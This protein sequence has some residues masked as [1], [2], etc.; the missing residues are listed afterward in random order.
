MPVSSTSVQSEI[1]AKG[2][3]HVS[4]RQRLGAHLRIARLDHS[5]KQLFIL[6]GI[7]LAMALTG[8]RMD[9]ALAINLCIGMISATLIASSNYVLN[10][11]LD[12]P[13]DRQHPTKKNRPAAC[14]LV[15]FGWGYAQ[16]ILMMIAG[17]TL[18]NMLFRGFLFSAIALWVMGCIYN[19]P[20][21][22]SK[23]LPYVDVL[24]ESI[25]NPIRFCL[26]WYMVTATLLPPASVLVSYW[27]LGAYFMALKRFSEYRQIGDASVAGSYRK[28]F[29]Y[30]NQESLLNSVVFYAAASMLFFGA[31]IMR[32]RIELILLFPLVAWLMAIYFGLSFRRESAVQNPEKLYREPRLMLVLALCTAVSVVLLFVNIPWLTL[33]FPRSL[34]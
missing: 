2:L 6:P 26:G 15:S 32:Y 12:A 19:I 20:P 10:E 14:R 13:F 34:P 8:R 33:F 27:M 18:A 1:L 17:L 21:I 25:N 3:T 5:I 4:V 7:V 23:D 31:F 9:S 30:Y 28:S 24:S 29:R 11:L 16:W 22:R